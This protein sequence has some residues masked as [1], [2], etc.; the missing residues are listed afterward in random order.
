MSFY[1]DGR[2]ARAELDTDVA[3]E[4]LRIA[5]R[6]HDM[7][8]GRLAD[9]GIEIEMDWVESRADLEEATESVR[10]GA[11]I[12]FGTFPARDNNAADAVTPV[13][14]DRDELVRPHPY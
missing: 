7:L 4:I 2:I 10:P 5:D 8:V 11:R 12:F 1:F 14:P 13:L 6:D 9:D 3:M